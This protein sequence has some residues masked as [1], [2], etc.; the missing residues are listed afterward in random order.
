MNNEQITMNKVNININELKN[1]ISKQGLISQYLKENLI[2]KLS[3]TLKEVCK[4]E[5]EEE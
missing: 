5:V 2:D 4:I 3:D 1:I